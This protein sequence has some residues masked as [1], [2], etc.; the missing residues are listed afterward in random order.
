[1]KILIDTDIFN[2]IDGEMILSLDAWGHRI[3]VKEVGS[4]SQVIFG[5]RRSPRHAPIDC[6]EASIDVPGFEDLQDD[7]GKDH[8]MA[9]SE[10]GSSSINLNNDTL[11][12]QDE[13]EPQNLNCDGIP[14][15]SPMRRKMENHKFKFPTLG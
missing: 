15:T 2:T 6:R 11:G 10:W 5:S 4:I 14:A 12:Y 13:A 1:M 3:H 9:A 8:D 7:M